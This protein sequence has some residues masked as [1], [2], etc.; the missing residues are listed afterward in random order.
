[1]AL[2]RLIIQMAFATDLTGHDLQSAAETAMQRA[3]SQA[4]LPAADMLGVPPGEI[5]TKVTLGVPDLGMLDRGA[6]ETQLPEGNATLTCVEG[7]Q[8][9]VDPVSGATQL[10][11]TAAAEVFLPRQTEWHLRRA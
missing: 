3:L 2:Q 6:L 9:V 4:D 8:K 1:M 7:G 11:V 5:V 10:V